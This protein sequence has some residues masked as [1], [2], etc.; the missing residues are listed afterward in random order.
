[1]RIGELAAKS[2]VSTRA[3]RYYEEQGILSSERTASGQ[4]TY[5]DSAVDRVR[6]IQQFYAA[7]LSSRM[8]ATI[9][10]CVDAGHAEPDLIE[11][12]RAERARIAA[13][14]TELEEAARNLDHVI[15]LAIHPDP[16]HCPALRL[17]PAAEA[18]PPL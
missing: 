1:M 5:A 18:T 10:P 15:D 14:I 11:S 12:L 8:I 2:N 13:S 16:E 9:L 4:R 17:H 6:L 3:L 7:G